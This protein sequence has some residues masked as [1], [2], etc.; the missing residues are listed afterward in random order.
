MSH[1][2]WLRQA[3]A[4][5]EA[6]RALSR[7][8]HHA[9]AVWLAAQAVEKA[10]KAILVVL[11]HDTSGFKKLSHKTSEIRKLLPETLRAPPDPELGA[12]VGELEKRGETCRYPAPSQP[13]G[14]K[15]KAVVA[16]SDFMTDSTKD[17]AD[18]ERLIA[19]CVDRIARA[20]R[21]VAAMGAP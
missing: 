20:Q 16:P 19:W 4:D 9:Q 5:L 6:A 10:H 21:G 3:Q 13:S 11:G 2:P 14:G 12:S 1:Q 8:G 17:I 7:A 18:A 15:S